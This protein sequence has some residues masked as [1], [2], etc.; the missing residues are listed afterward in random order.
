MK[1]IAIIIAATTLFLG[2]FGSP[3]QRFIKDISN[4]SN[5]EEIDW[6]VTIE[7]FYD[8]FDWNAHA[9]S[10]LYAESPDFPE[11]PELYA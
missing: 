3:E 11:P 5:Y 6:D 7:K 4:L 1:S 8:V 9:R 10:Q 2:C